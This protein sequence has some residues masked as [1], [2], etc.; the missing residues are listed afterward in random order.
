[1]CGIVMY[2]RGDPPGHAGLQQAGGAVRT[3][4][5]QT[6]RRPREGEDPSDPARTATEGSSVLS[7]ILTGRK[8][9]P[10]LAGKKRNLLSGFFAHRPG[11]P[12]NGRIR[13]SSL[14]TF[15]HKCIELPVAG[16]NPATVQYDDE[17]ARRGRRTS[18]RASS[19]S[20]HPG[21]GRDPMF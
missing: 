3:P 19:R 4:H 20:R 6:G 12:Q 2:V 15:Q 17:L 13:Y 7:A 18:S 21:A 5:I 9:P 14:P 11:Y 16:I 10:T 8:R 1:M